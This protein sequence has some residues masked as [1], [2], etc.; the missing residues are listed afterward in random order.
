[1]KKRGGGGDGRLMMKGK[2][3]DPNKWTPHRLFHMYHFRELMNA[4]KFVEL[5]KLVEERRLK[6]SGCFDLKRTYENSKG[7]DISYV[8]LSPLFRHFL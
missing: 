1:M 4:N 5:E 2:V 3:T 6:E 8:S 7:W